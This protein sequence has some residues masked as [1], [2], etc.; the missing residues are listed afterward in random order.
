MCA[1]FLEAAKV[2]LLLHAAIIEYHLF[3][4]GIVCVAAKVTLW[5]RECQMFVIG[6]SLFYHLL[7]ICV[8]QRRYIS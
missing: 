5:E 1:T 8:L 7:D 2:G 3:L 6:I 4:I